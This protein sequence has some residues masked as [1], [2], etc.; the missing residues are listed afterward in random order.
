M[1]MN[2]RGNMDRTER[3]SDRIS[4]L[5]PVVPFVEQEEG[6]SQYK[7]LNEAFYVTNDRGYLKGSTEIW[8]MKPDFFRDGISGYNWLVKKDLLPIRGNVG[9]THIFLGSVAEHNLDRIFT[10]MQGENWS[11][12]GQARNFIRSRRL[13]HTSMSVG[14]I[15]KIGSKAFLVDSSGFKE[16]E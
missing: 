6:V 12:D 5:P 8:Y 7:S 15:I 4:A 14:D 3:I 11:P 10:M 9:L 1:K 2:R 16:L 13:Q